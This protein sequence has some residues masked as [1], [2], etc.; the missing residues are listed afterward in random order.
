[1]PQ[2]I[3]LPQHALHEYQTDG[4]TDGFRDQ[5]RKPDA[6]SLRENTENHQ[7]D[8]LDHDSAPIRNN[9]RPPGLLHRRQESGNHDIKHNRRKAQTVD[10]NGMCCSIDFLRCGIFQI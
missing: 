10:P 3:L 5:R 4:Q 9:H 7:N 2:S 1:M 8:C 6:L